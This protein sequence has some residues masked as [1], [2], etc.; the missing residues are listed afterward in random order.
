MDNL[1]ISVITSMENFISL[2]EE[3]ENILSINIEDNF[4]YSFDWYY[5]ASHFFIDPIGSPFIICV[6][7]KQKVIAILP[8]CIIRKRLRLFS[9]NSLEFI[10]NIY[11]AYRG[12]VVLKGKENVV[13]AAVAD[14]LLITYRTSWDIIHFEDMS[15]SDAFL[16]TLFQVIQSR[17]NVITRISEQYADLIVDIEPGMSSLDYWQSRGKNLKHNIRRRINKMN[18]EGIFMIVPTTHSGQDIQSAMDHYYE[19]FRHSW[20]EPEIDPQFHRKL[21]TYLMEKGKLRLFTLYF[22]K[23][24]PHSVNDNN[25]PILSY[26]SDLSPD[27]SIPK[28]YLPISTYFCAVSGSYACVLK[29]AYHEDFSSYS[30]SSVLEWFTIKW[31]LDMDNVTVIDFQ[32]H[33]DVYKFDW[34]RVKEMHV[35]FQAANSRN[36][37][38]VLEIWG[39]KNLIPLLRKIKRARLWLTANDYLRQYADRG[40]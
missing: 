4:Y 3:W 18:R 25:F 11:S 38:A 33:D 5:A 22:K 15:A 14:S 23:G 28:G 10:G 8:C 9:F 12:G 2:K 32:K 21:A 27:Q 36:L 16:S 26:E 17:D 31:L 7:I 13:A 29:S 1:D 6:K 40:K 39:E 34:G 19:I 35:L 20:K 24:E 30:S 37:L